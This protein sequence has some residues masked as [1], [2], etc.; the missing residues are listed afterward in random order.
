MQLKLDK[1]GPKYRTALNYCKK[2]WYEQNVMP[3]YCDRTNGTTKGTHSKFHF[4]FQNRYSQ[5]YSAWE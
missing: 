1:N 4:C 2:Q 3:P 5:K